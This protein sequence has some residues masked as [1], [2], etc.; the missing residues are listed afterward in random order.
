M[1]INEEIAKASTE[2]CTP[3]CLR[4]T[5]HIKE[6]R[7]STHCSFQEEDLTGQKHWFPVRLTDTVRQAGRHNVWNQMDSAVLHSAAWSC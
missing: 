6:E 7:K 5:D 3:T 2:G 1:L 4:Y